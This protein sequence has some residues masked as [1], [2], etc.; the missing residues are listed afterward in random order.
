MSAVAR[1]GSPPTTAA[2]LEYLCLFTHD[3]RR[4]QKRWQDGRLKY[5]AFNKRVMVH[6]ERGNFVGDMHWQ[7]DYEFDEGEEVELDRGGIIVQVSNLVARS[8]TDLSELLDKR[9]KEKEQ[10]QTRQIARS[11]APAAMLP[12]PV[13]RPSVIPPDHFQLRHRS[14]HQVIGT[15]TGH[16]GRALVP[17]ESPFEQRHQAAAAAAAAA[18]SPDERAAKRR[19]HDDP[20]PSKSG[21]AKS[22][23]GQSLTLSATPASSGPVKSRARPGLHMSPPAQADLPNAQEEATPVPREKPRLSRHRNEKSGYAQGLFGQSLTLSHTPVASV[24]PRHQARYEPSST[25]DPDEDTHDGRCEP[26]SALR[27][28]PKASHHFNQSAS[29][30]QNVIPGKA[31]SAK[32]NAPENSNESAES[33]VSRGKVKGKRTIR[34]PHRVHEPGNVALVD[35]DVIEIDDPEVTSVQA[36]RPPRRGD[37]VRKTARNKQQ[38]DGGPNFKAAKNPLSREKSGFGRSVEPGDEQES[39]TEKPE[40]SALAKRTKAVVPR[41]TTS[42]DTASHAVSNTTPQDTSLSFTT[43]RRSY[44]QVTEL[45]IKSRKRGLLMMSDTAKKSRRLATENS[46]RST[47]VDFEESFDKPDSGA[48][49]SPV[50]NQ[51]AVSEDEE[52]RNDTKATRVQRKISIELG[53]PDDPFRSLSPELLERPVHDDNTSTKAR[54]DQQKQLSTEA[55]RESGIGLPLDDSDIVDEDATIDERTTRLSPASSRKPDPYRIPSSPEEEIPFSW[56]ASSPRIRIP[57]TNDGSKKRSADA[58]RDA[59]EAVQGPTAATKHKQQR[60]SRRRIVFE[61]D[62]EPVPLEPMLDDAEDDGPEM[63]E[64]APIQ[65]KSK[66]AKRANNKRPKRVADPETNDEEEQASRACPEPEDEQVGTRRRSARQKRNRLDELERPH[67]SSEQDVSEE[68]QRPKKR[69]SRASKAAENRPRL[70]R[71]K[72]NIKSRELIGFNLA[73]LNAPLGPRGIG[74]PFKI[75]SSPLDESILRRGTNEAVAETSS[76]PVLEDGDEQASAVA[77]ITHSTTPESDRLVVDNPLSTVLTGRHTT[78]TPR[79]PAAS[80]QVD[81]DTEGDQAKV[82]VPLAT[83]EDPAPSA[84]SDVWPTARRSTPVGRE[85]QSNA[86]DDTAPESS[87]QIV[88]H[89]TRNTH[90]TSAPILAAVTHIA[91]PQ[92]PTNGHQ[93]STSKT[94]N[95][96]EVGVK[97]G[98]TGITSSTGSNSDISSLDASAADAGTVTQLPSG[99]SARK[100][101]PAIQQQLAKAQEECDN[102]EV[103]RETSDSLDDNQQERT[104]GP[105]TRSR[106]T[107]PFKKPTPAMRKQPSLATNGDEHRASVTEDGR[108]TM[109]GNKDNYGSASTAPLNIEPPLQK[110]ALALTRSASPGEIDTSG[111]PNT[112]GESGETKQAPLESVQRPKPISLVRQTSAPQRVNNITAVPAQ[113][114]APGVQ[115]GETAAKAGA[116]IVNPAS[117]GRKAALASDA[118]GPVPQRILPPTQPA[119][120]VPISTA[121]L[122][123]TPFEEPPKEPERPKRK[124]KFPGFQSAK[125]VG[126]W[127]REA[128]DLLESGRPE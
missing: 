34:Q 91:P 50:L 28:Q 123:C 44:E 59:R 21:Y 67:L 75:L 121:D 60:P 96:T 47:E 45:R 109:G 5:H 36:I 112:S 1:S 69:Q 74:M 46:S 72:K 37:V 70:E 11:P 48:V 53:E 99:A 84:V 62:D 41:S 6:D 110:S 85:Q 113:T 108:D 115:T 88:L 100:S 40:G 106:V 116:R 125:G 78:P 101:S 49:S 12:R 22:L 124:M 25:V 9:A 52:P 97:L 120:L 73:A 38:T 27:E 117:R 42:R 13:S 14:L 18:E 81:F 102:T 29:R 122:A 2:V 19:K 118:V 103:A 17:N 93:P 92:A 58:V 54:S 68:E 77:S 33:S 30:L 105:A 127:S 83:H 43:S 39:E 107:A 76:D 26:Q 56:P 89:S 114:G 32:H 98:K 55:L 64:T 82:S 35:D 23:F 80:S 4:K 63:T 87:P 31:I 104:T 86:A 15:P 94:T 128:F 111:K 126:P 3:L 71:I 95:G 7:Q 119:L 8:E 65:S 51:D 79:S 61:D 90:T 16:H 66:K 10:R 57:P 24:P 20:P